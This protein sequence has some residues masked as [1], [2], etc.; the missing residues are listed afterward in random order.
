MAIPMLLVATTATVN[1]VATKSEESR[2]VSYGQLVPVDGKNMNVVISGQGSETIVL[3]PG[4]GTASPGLDFD[5]LIKE[6]SARHRVIAVE[7]FG[8]GLSDQTETER[9]AA[10]ITREVHEALQ[11]LGVERYALMGH[12]IAGVYALSYSAS[13]GNE[14]IAWIGID[15]SVPDQPGWNEPLPSQAITTFKNLGIT[16]VL[17]SIAPDPYAGLPYDDKTKE[18]MRL[19]ST[20][21]SAA[22]TLV[23][24]MEN[25]PANF[26]GVSGMTFPKELPVLLF[27]AANSADVQGWDKLHEDQ[28]ESVVN[29]K[30]VALEGDHYLHHT[31]SPEIAESTTAFLS[32]LTLR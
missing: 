7:P 3:L 29:G 21:N 4:L 16:R 17:A 8:T 9:T 32:T 31:Q 25:T 26:A 28:A 6:L 24:E 20:K 11:Y 27:V 13:Y 2:I 22:P 1:A 14:L 18:Q 23:S 12:S 5:P 30:V 15:S 19:L 10:N